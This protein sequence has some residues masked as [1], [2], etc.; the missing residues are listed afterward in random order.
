MLLNNKATNL[1]Y[2]LYSNTAFPNQNLFNDVSSANGLKIGATGSSFL[3]S[4]GA[5][6][7]T[8]GGVSASSS[9]SFLMTSSSDQQRA[10]RKQRR[11]RTTFT[12]SQLRELER[13]FQETHYPDIYTREDL[14]MKVDLTEA[15]V[16]V[17][18]GLVTV[19]YRRMLC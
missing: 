7:A 9:S 5:A 15:R 4:L 11:I 14:A 8:S 6:A 13:A 1:P 10:S 3:G 17:R 12:S 18:L 2:K 16:Q 19:T